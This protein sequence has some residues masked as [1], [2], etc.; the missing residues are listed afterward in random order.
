MAKSSKEVTKTK[1]KEFHT[2]KII[3]TNKRAYRAY[4]I[5]EK[6]EA[7]IQLSGSE[8]K[9]LTFA[10]IDLK[11]GFV[12][13]VDG[14]AYLE[15]TSIPIYQQASWTNHKEKRKRKLLLHKREISKLTKAIEQKGMTIVPVRF[16]RIKGKYKVEVALAQGKKIY[17]K[18]ET[19][20]QRDS[21]IEAARLVKMKSYR[22]R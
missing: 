22:R 20:K 3:A 6:F 8:A 17:D 7:G 16:Y 12:S 14:E 15:Q 9:S 1:T 2:K 18:R 21:E 5:L 19:I 11:G 4:S 10:P 13:I